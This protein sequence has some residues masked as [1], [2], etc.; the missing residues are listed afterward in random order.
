MYATFPDSWPGFGL[1]LLRAT[2]GGVSLVRCLSYL[3]RWNEIGVLQVVVILVTLASSVL[4]V[5]GYRTR[6]AAVVSSLAGLAVAF[7]WLF[8]G[9]FL[10]SR[11]SGALFSA[12][13]VALICLGPGA[14]SL[15]SRLFGRREIVIPKM[16][17][18]N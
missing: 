5:L 16:R 17:P 6:T 10:D 8:N 15:D 7:L 18:K 4:L 12:I 13:T 14:F 11:L 1:L 3:A 9:T 2:A